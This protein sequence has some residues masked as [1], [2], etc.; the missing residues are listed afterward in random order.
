M[1]I[2]IT[3]IDKISNTELAAKQ[4]PSGKSVCPCPNFQ[5]GQE[6]FTTF[7]KPSGFCEWAWADIYRYV[8]IFLS[9]GNMGDAFN[10][11]TDNNKVIACCTDAIRPVVF[12]IEKIE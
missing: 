10:W 1:E 2:K 12:K 6:F 9:G 11:M 8:A 7:E 4:C 5:V 3:V